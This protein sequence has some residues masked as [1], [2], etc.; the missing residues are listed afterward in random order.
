MN[1]TK[2]TQFFELSE[3]QKIEFE[4]DF[5]QNLSA[6]AASLATAACEIHEPY[7]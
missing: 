4:L 7:N 1:F 5:A 6:L 2:L 3:T